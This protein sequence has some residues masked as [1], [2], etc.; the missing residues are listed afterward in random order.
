MRDH[1]SACHGGCGTA[2]TPSAC[3]STVIA[4]APGMTVPPPVT[5]PIPA[6]PAP[7]AMPNVNKVGSAYGIVRP[8]LTPVAG[9]APRTIDLAPN[10]F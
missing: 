5:A 3:G 6:P 8:E 2:A 4:P 10:P 7:K 9:S 1:G